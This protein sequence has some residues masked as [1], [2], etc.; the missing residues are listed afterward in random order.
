[1]NSNKK[2]QLIITALL[3]STLAII[4][5]QIFWLYNTYTINKENEKLLI[6]NSVQDALDQVRVKTYFGLESTNSKSYY[7]FLKSISE[8]ENLIDKIEV[9][10][11]NESA[12]FRKLKV[13]TAGIGELCIPCL[14]NNDNKIATNNIKIKIPTKNTKV[15]TNK[16]IDTIIY[17]DR[18]NNNPEVFVNV[19]SVLKLRDSFVNRN[20]VIKK[21]DSLGLNID[22]KSDSVVRLVT[23]KITQQTIKFNE[24]EENPV[25]KKAKITK[26]IIKKKINNSSSITPDEY[27]TILTENNKLDSIS[28]D[29][30][31]LKLILDSLIQ[32]KLNDLSLKNKFDINIYSKED[33]AAVK[34]DTINTLVA[35]KKSISPY[36]LSVVSVNSELITTISQM[37]WPLLLSLLIVVV[38]LYTS[39]SLI[40]SFQKEKQLS[41]IKNDF[42][43]NMTHEFKTPIATISL[44]VELMSKFGIKDN[45]E[46]LEEYLLIC[47][48]ELKRVSSMIETVLRLAQE[49]PYILQRE[50]TDVH[51][52]LHNLKNQ[53]KA[54]ITDVNGSIDYV[55]EDNFPLVKVDKVHFENILHNLLDNSIKYSESAPKINI[56]L[57][58][59][60]DNFILTFQDNGIGIPKEYQHE[61]FNNFFRVPT[62]NIHNQ[63]GFGLGLT[64]VKKIVELHGG[65]IDVYSQIHQ[66]TTFTI[67]IPIV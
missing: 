24:N 11:Q 16:K 55:I 6:Q 34:L 10:E 51:Y 62:A 49:N 25:Q 64:Y 50:T 35:V 33:S 9:I 59:A 13:D 36:Y 46:K 28:K 32:S 23:N 66:G 41:V 54:K 37:K 45:P 40:R 61:I 4:I 58:R 1:M 5:M 56:S 2:A 43:S 42:I 38:L 47:T 53:N 26:P 7:N 29:S 14:L 19:D 67:Q 39:T 3:I 18:N 44:A 63:K 12:K 17:Y 15:L 8:N 21:L 22:L 52:I 48:N 30:T 27:N 65:T 57:K 20:F 31:Q 60:N